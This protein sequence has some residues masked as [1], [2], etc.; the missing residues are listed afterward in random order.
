M[1]HQSVEYAVQHFR[2]ATHRHFRFGVKLDAAPRLFGFGS[3]IADDIGQHLGK[4][5][6]V[7]SRLDH[8]GLE[9]GKGQ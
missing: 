6:D 1:A 3:R 8:A 2:I 4:I 7:L 5:D 9:P